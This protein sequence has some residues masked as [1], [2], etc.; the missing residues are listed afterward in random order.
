M[1]HPLDHEVYPIGTVVRIIETGEFA[2]IKLQTFQMNGSGFLHYLG[3]IEGRTGLY[4]IIHDRVDVE[5]FPDD[6]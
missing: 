4:C 2:V 5:C 6:F 3:E 1:A